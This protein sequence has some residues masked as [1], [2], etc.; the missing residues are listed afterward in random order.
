MP[1]AKTLIR[2]GGC[3]AHMPFCWFCHEV[4]HFVLMNILSATFVVKAEHVLTDMHVNV[5]FSDHQNVC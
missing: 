1:T 3:L 5:K 4:A 2:L